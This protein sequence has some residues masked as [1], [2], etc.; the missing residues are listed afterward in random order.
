LSRILR[1]LVVAGAVL[2]AMPLSA[3]AQ[4]DRDDAGCRATSIYE[5][6]RCVEYGERVRVNPRDESMKPVFGVFRGFTGDSLVVE[7]GRHHSS[8]LARMLSARSR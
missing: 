4:G 8:S 6:P 5:L 2:V 3:V 1:A 7:T